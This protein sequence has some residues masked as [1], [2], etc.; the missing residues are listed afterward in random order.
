MK[1]LINSPSLSALE[2]KYVNDVLKSTW[3][4]SN[5]KHTLEFEKKVSKLLNIKNSLAVQSGTAAL[6]LALK[7]LGCNYGDRVILPNYSCSSNLT[8]VTQCG[9]IPIIVEVEEATLGLDINLLK[10]AIIKYKPKIVQLVHVYGFPAKDTIEIVKL[11]KKKK[12][13]LVEDFSEALGAKI[14][15][16]YV[17]SFGDIGV[18]SIR[19]EKMIGVGEG[20]VI[21]TNSNSKYILANRLASRNSPFRGKRD[22]YW[23]K[24]HSLG[25]GYNYKLPHLLGA[26]GRGQ[27]E[28]FKKNILPKKIK[29]GKIYSKLF[30]D[31]NFRITQKFFKGSVPVYWLNS[32][33]FKN[34]SKNKIRK[35]GLDLQKKGIEVRSGFWPLNLI[36]SIKSKYVYKKKI[37]KKI[38]EKTLVLPSNTQ[39]SVNDVRLIKKIIINN[40]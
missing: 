15:N 39:L 34:I 9:A 26:I 8:S 24:Y 20:G 29:I 37:S 22:P 25:E 14:N 36:K 32:V 4:S 35:I 11:C 33:Y 3:L 38:F 12:I 27:I 7:T 31:K 16:K 21:V 30:N 6:H 1:Y 2:K 10:K 28:R 13:S 5:G 18:F 40:L 19:S 23:K 17:G